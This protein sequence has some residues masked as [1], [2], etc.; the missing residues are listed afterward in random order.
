M[1]FRR[2]PRVVLTF[3]Q[4]LLVNLPQPLI[5]LTE[6]KRTHIYLTYQSLDRLKLLVG[7][8]PSSKMSRVMPTGLALELFKKLW[9]HTDPDNIQLAASAISHLKVRMIL[10]LTD[11]S[12]RSQ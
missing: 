3:E 1:I 7:R 8:V 9:D 6:P 10:Q 11:Y 5:Y 2:P 12:S 4:F